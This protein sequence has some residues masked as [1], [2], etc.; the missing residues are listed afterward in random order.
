MEG[1]GG[2]DMKNLIEYKLNCYNTVPSMSMF[3]IVEH[4]KR[5]IKF[6]QK[7]LI[8]SHFRK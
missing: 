8:S 2:G 6:E 5:I 4:K 7:S 3:G 1:V